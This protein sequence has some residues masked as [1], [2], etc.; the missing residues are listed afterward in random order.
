MIIA[1]TCS[2]YKSEILK[3][4]HADTDVY[5]LALFTS[6]ASLGPS[7]TSYSGQDGE[8]AA[9]GG[10]DTGGKALTGF[11]V[12]LTNGTAFL[13]FED[14]AWN[15]ATIRARGGLIYNSSK[16]NK[17]VAVIDFGQDIVSSNAPFTVQFP[18][19]DAEHA[20]I[21]LN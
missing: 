10:Y 15:P 13:D 7:V 1:G 18:V 8:V 2:S 4:V 20:F 19:A 16:G 12:G 5:K 6:T 3:G 21:A 17:A 14:P 11:A 9:T